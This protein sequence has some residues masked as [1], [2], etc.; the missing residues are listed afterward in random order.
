MNLFFKINF[1]K[2]DWI[3]IKTKRNET[4][5]IRTPSTQQKWKEWNEI[6]L[7][8]TWQTMANG[9]GRRKRKRKRKMEEIPQC[10]SETNWYAF[11][12]YHFCTF[13][14]L[15][16]WKALNGNRIYFYGSPEWERDDAIKNALQPFFIILVWYPCTVSCMW[17]CPSVGLCV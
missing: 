15:E 11:I 14:W 7:L 16:R 12:S 9:N 6:K 3:L 2:F 10:G 5:K 17:V 1:T 4:K 13:R 8:I